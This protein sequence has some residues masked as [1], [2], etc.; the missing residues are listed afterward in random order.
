MT[1]D[2]AVVQLT[3]AVALVG[4]FPALA[5]ATLTLQSREVVGLRGPNG[6]GKSTLLRLCAGLVALRRGSGEVLGCDLATRGG[7]RAVRRSVGL[8][9]HETSLYDDLTVAE[10]IR[11][12]SGAHRA[13]D[14]DAGAAMDHLGLS[15][16]LADVPVAGLSA[17]QRRRTAIA[18]VVARRPRLWLLDEPH[19]GLD[20]S[21]RD[22][23]DRL[24]LDAAASGATV[25]VATHD[26]GRIDD[27][28]TRCVEVEG[29]M[30]RESVD[31]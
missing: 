24:M 13:D 4:G 6:A 15:G 1:S 7:R 16:R 23:L 10:N 5:G 20:S 14:D 3:D 19:A 27:V 17:G 2:G 26:R 30:V 12:W 11:F 29:G 31:G 21:G 25:L 9:G 8:L 22:L 18:V 28:L